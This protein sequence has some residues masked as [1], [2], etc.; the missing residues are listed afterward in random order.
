M[1]NFSSN[2]CETYNLV[3]EKMWLTLKQELKWNLWAPTTLSKHEKWESASF[4]SQLVI[5]QVWLLFAVSVI[6]THD[7]K[8]AQKLKL[9][10][11]FLFFNWTQPIK[12]Y[13]IR[14]LNS[15]FI[16]IFITP[17]LLWYVGL[18]K[19][20]HLSSL[21]TGRLSNNSEIM[22]DVDILQ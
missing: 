21:K 7:F 1:L 18:S 2:E 5:V 22:L 4:L 10:K 9:S 8:F 12:K 6:Y 20:L 11:A 17:V 3:W 15:H 13:L 19:K 16:P 14:F